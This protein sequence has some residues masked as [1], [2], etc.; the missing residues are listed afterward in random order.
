M[1]KQSMITSVAREALAVVVVELI[2][3][4]APVSAGIADALVDVL[5]ALWSGP[6]R[7]ADAEVAHRLSFI[8]THQSGIVT[9]AMHISE[10]NP[11]RKALSSRDPRQYDLNWRSREEDF[12]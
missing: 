11:A 5:S 12:N 3:A 9:K 6:A 2:D 8:H 4:Y 7:L 1:K 10:N